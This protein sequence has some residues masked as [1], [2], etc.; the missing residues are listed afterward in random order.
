[1]SLFLFSC[2]TMESTL[3][4]NDNA[5]EILNIL[6][7][8]EQRINKIFVLSNTQDIVLAN[9]RVN[10]DIFQIYN[11]EIQVFELLDGKN[12]V[13]TFLEAFGDE[14]YNCNTEPY[15]FS[16][17]NFQDYKTHYF[18][19]KEHAGKEFIGRQVNCYEDLHLT[20]EA[21]FYL[22]NNPRS[23]LNTDWILNK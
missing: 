11:K 16:T 2:T 15:V 9:T 21:F 19:I 4:K 1:M 17:K 12:S 7:S 3:Q 18:M 22:K 8:P 13:Y 23:R 20:E 10:E 6:R 14:V 5:E